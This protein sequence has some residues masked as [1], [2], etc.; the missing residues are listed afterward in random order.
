MAED[1]PPT[2]AIKQAWIEAH[3]FRAITTVEERV[4][5]FD[6]WLAEVRRE[7][8]ALTWREGYRRGTLDATSDLEPADNPYQQEETT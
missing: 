3:P 1:T 7:A 4:A 6:R 5:E 2:S 8:A